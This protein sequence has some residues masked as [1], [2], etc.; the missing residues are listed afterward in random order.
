MAK[1]LKIRTQGRSVDDPSSIRLEIRSL[2][3]VRKDIGCA[4]VVG[5]SR[6]FGKFRVHKLFALARL[7]RSLAANIP[8]GIHSPATADDG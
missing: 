2:N 5:K 7:C 1:V 6:P 8:V 4:V 3:F